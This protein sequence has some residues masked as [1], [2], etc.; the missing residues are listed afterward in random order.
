MEQADILGPLWA[1]MG[2]TFAVWV[3]MFARRVPFIQASGMTPEQ[4]VT[5]GYLASVSPVEIVNPSDNLKNLFEMPVLFYAVVL[6][7]FASG[8]VDGVHVGSA[9]VFVAFRAL[10]SLMHCTLNIVTVRFVLYLIS[11]FA[12]W[13]MI[14]RG[15][16]AWLDG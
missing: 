10:H 1:M 13:V 4:M 2:L 3:Y 16:L 6:T 8:Q 15:A 11:S 7:L 12:L 5:P 9:W 14:A